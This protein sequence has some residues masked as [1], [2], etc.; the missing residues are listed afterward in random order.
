V[1]A[2]QFGVSKTARQNRHQVA[3]VG[4][5]DNTGC[6]ERTSL[7]ASLWGVMTHARMT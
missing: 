5:R 7:T 3:A 1:E 2:A 6:F 4:Q